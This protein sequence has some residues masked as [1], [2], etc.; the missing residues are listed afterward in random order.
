[1]LLNVHNRL[2]LE[3]KE[4]SCFLNDDLKVGILNRLKIGLNRFIQ[5]RIL[6]KFLT[7]LK[8]P[9]YHELVQKTGLTGF[10]PVL[11]KLF[12]NRNIFS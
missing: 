9:V 12:Q 6:I 10:E 3:L 2:V 1:M 8:K 5:K 4:N 7:F 11:Q